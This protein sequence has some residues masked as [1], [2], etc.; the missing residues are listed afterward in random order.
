MS[1]TA[2]LTLMFKSPQRSKQ[3]LAGEIGVRAIDAAQQL[4]ACA[5]ADL[6][7]WSGP[8]CLAPAGPADALYART[9]GYVADMQI[10]QSEGNLGRRIESIAAVLTSAGHTRQIFIGS[11]CPGLDGA[12]LQAATAAL[13]TA[14]VVLGPA[15]DGGVVLMGVRGSW[16]PLEPLP[17]SSSQLG[18]SLYRQCESAE[19]H[20]AMLD[21]RSDV[22]TAAELRRV[23][24]ALRADTRPTRRKLCS[25]IV[26]EL[27]V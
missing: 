26:S 2:C 7:A 1:R 27:Q 18:E 13:D 20:V 8:T 23:P 9:H 5:V 25:W 4:L 15:T 17:W 21:E 12:Y 10:V 14:D 24:E 11:D 22:D 6:Q 3:R 19:L 16:P